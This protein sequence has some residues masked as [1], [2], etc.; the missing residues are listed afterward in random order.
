MA[1]VQTTALIIEGRI[2]IPAAW[3]AM[4]NGD[5][6]AVPL[7][8]D[9]ASLSYGLESISKTSQDENNDCNL[10]NHS[11]YQDTQNIEEKNTEE[12]FLRGIWSN[13][14]GVCCFRT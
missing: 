10:H 12:C 5:E 11:H 6:A 2:L 14:S 3:K 1:D 8:T 4:T 9:R 13:S 7:G